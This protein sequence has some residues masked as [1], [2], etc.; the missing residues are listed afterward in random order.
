MARLNVNV[1]SYKYIPIQI[2]RQ[3]RGLYQPE[4]FA[5]WGLTP[6]KDWTPIDE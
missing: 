2:N 6:P 3:G 4:E 5:R 1:K